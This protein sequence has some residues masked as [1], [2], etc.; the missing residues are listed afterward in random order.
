MSAEAETARPRR[1]DAWP[2]RFFGTGFAFCTF[3]F[4]G[5]IFRLLVWPP[6]MLLV[7]DNHRRRN[8]A[9]SL[10]H[11]FFRAFIRML[12]LLTVIVCDVR[13]VER[14]RL[15]GALIVANHP[16]L[17]DVVLLVSLVPD[18]C[19][20]VKKELWSNPFMN[21]PLRAAGYIDNGDPVAMFEAAQ[22]E[23][24]SGASLVIFP[25]GTRTERGS[26]PAFG[27]SAANL[28]VRSRHPIV[29]VCIQ[30][31]PTTLTRNE[32]WYEVPYRR[33]WFTLTVGEILEPTPAA[34]VPVTIQVR[35]M[36]E[37]LLAFIYR[38]LEQPAQRVTRKHSGPEP[39][40]PEA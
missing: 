6:L 14:L 12:E 15:P 23:L 33:V 32:R 7:Q 25:E 35:R 16:S 10:I 38:Q 3:A 9:R 28:A 40:T 37:K 18:A 26:A 20:V 17:L 2:L 31:D 19:C 36:Q 39:E 27:R 5:I 24:E 22:A 8:I 1:Q 30:V 11:H 34:D 13:Q 4:M 29:P 21:G